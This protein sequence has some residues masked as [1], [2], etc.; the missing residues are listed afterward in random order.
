M[1]SKVRWAARAVGFPEAV[2]RKYEASA[3][4]QEMYAGAFDR[5][6]APEHVVAYIREMRKADGKPLRETLPHD[7]VLKTFV[8]LK[9]GTL[10]HESQ[11]QLKALKRKLRD[12]LGPKRVK[13]YPAVSARV[14]HGA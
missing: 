9:R 5:P 2:R 14:R 8:D 7:S 12:S 1:K 10:D 6:D 4:H 3:S 11:E 13:S